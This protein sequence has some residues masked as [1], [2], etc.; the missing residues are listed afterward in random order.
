MPSLA[1]FYLIVYTF[2]TMDELKLEIKQTIISALQLEDI[3]PD[4]IDDAAPLFEEGLG[5]DSIDALEL[6]VALKRKFGIKSSSE[7]DDNKKYYAS[8]N[9]LAEYIAA[10]KA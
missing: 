5:L 2:E 6:G 3:T 1:F 10:Q 7:S 9:A 8:V 4:D